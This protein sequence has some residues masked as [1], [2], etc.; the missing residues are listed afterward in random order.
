MTHDGVSRLI[1]AA[2]N[3]I[4]FLICFIVKYFAHT[5]KLQLINLS[6]NEKLLKI[7]TICA[8]CFLFSVITW[9]S[10]FSGW[11]TY[12]AIGREEKRLRVGIF[13]FLIGSYANRSVIYHNS[14]LVLLSNASTTNLSLHYESVVNNQFIDVLM[15]SFM[16]RWFR[17]FSGMCLRG[18][19]WTVPSGLV[20]LLCDESFLA[21]EYLLSGGSMGIIY[22]I[23]WDI[24]SQAPN[25]GQGPDLAEFIFGFLLTFCLLCSILGHY[26]GSL[27]SSFRYLDLPFTVI[28]SVLSCSLFLGSAITYSFVTQSDEVNRDQSLIGIIV[29]TI[30]ILLVILPFALNSI[31]K[32][33]KLIPSEKYA[34]EEILDENSSMLPINENMEEKERSNASYHWKM[35]SLFAICLRI[36]FVVVFLTLLATSVTSCVWFYAYNSVN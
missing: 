20:L 9:F 22:E 25:F 31:F 1:W 36:F 19:L 26:P 18:L 6:Q 15:W 7:A 10:L 34:K 16:R 17:D 28:I 3:G 35:F 27:S 24:P 32:I 8:Y 21:W 29:P 5:T 4:L 33:I 2:P 23:A 13:D 11:T 12:M 30:W 14:S